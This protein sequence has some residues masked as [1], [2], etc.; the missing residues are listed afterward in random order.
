MYVDVS[1]RMYIVTLV[2]AYLFLYSASLF[3]VMESAS[4]DRLGS[5]TF[6]ISYTNRR[7]H[8]NHIVQFE[9]CY[10]LYEVSHHFVTVTHKHNSSSLYY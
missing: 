6:F 5:R 1:V 9:I 10:L 8:I 2:S 4:S 7:N 3:A